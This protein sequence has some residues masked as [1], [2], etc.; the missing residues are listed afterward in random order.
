MSLQL[1]DNSIDSLLSEIDPQDRNVV[2]SAIIETDRKICVKDIR[3]LL[4]PAAPPFLNRLA[5]QS[6]AL[7]S[8]Q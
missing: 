2:L 5:K 4:S 6:K 3:C 7:S 8:F 1:F